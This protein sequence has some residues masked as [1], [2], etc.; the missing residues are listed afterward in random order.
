MLQKNIVTI[1]FL[2]F[3]IAPLHPSYSHLS[4]LSNEYRRDLSPCKPN[5]PYAH[6]YTLHLYMI[7]NFGNWL[8][9]ASQAPRGTMW[10]VAL[11]PDAIAKIQELEQRGLSRVQRK[12]NTQEITEIT[13]HLVSSDKNP[14]ELKKTIATV[15]TS[16]LKNIESDI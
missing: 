12:K 3:F 4:T 13:T 16:M 2:C 8:C 14:D 1:L 7:D 9:R 15:I 5:T 10:N 11:S 6:K